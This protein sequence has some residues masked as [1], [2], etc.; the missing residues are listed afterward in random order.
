MLLRF[1]MWDFVVWLLSC[2]GILTLGCLSGQSVF[3]NL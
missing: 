1:I 3:L 2:F